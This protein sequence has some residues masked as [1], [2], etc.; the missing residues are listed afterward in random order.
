MR[1]AAEV[2]MAGSGLV[3]C[4]SYRYIRFAVLMVSF[5]RSILYG[6]RTLF[7]GGVCW[8]NQ[9]PRPSMTWTPEAVAALRSR[10]G[11]SQMAFAEALGFT[12]AASVSDLETG[13]R[14]VSGTVA[15]LL[16]VLDGHGLAVMQ[17]KAGG[18]TSSASLA[19]ELRRIAGEIER[20]EG[21]GQ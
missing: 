2:G 7:C 10:L 12:R 19:A 16:D 14:D 20:M 4:L 15:R 8:G 6:L 11:L 13:R 1:A 17:P 9:D 3:G 21:T 5:C 18:A